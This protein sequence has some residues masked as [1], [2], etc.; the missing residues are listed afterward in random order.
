MIPYVLSSHLRSF[1]SKHWI[2]E[3]LILIKELATDDC[4]KSIYVIKEK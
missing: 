1:L 2:S 4:K 3:Y